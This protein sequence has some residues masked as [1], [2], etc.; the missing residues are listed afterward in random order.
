MNTN[1]I[2]GFNTLTVS[3]NNLRYLRRKYNEG[4]SYKCGEWRVGVAW[5]P[6]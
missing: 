2:E 4:R 6:K 3:V 5:Q 1:K